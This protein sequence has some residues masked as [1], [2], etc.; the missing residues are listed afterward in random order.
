MWAEEVAKELALIGLTFTK[1]TRLDVQ[2]VQG[3][4][5]L[6]LPSS[7]IIIIYHH[8]WLIFA[9]ILGT[10]VRY[11]DLQEVCLTN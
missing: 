1:Q 10:K 8:V 5:C 11:L 2:R 6:H 3:P 7:R 4:S 9:W